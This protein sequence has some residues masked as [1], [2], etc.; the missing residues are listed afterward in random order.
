MGSYSMF[1]RDLQKEPL[2]DLETKIEKIFNHLK[3]QS[4]VLANDLKELKVYKVESL[5]SADSVSIT[6]IKLWKLG[7]GVYRKHYAQILKKLEECCLTRVIVV[8]HREWLPPKNFRGTTRRPSSKFLEH[9][10]THWIDDVIYPFNFT[11]VRKRFT[12]DGH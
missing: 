12:Q 6:L 5:G 1:S 9:V 11:S 3:E 10:H 2:T 8:R 4:D 7:W